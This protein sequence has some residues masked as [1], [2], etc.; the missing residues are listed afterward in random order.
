[1]NTT[2]F[3]YALE[4]ERTRSITQAAE[5]LLI[6]QPTSARRCGR[7]RTRSGT[8][9]STARRAARS[10]TEKGVRFL[11]IAREITQ[12]LKK[13]EEIG[14]LG[15][16]RTQRLSVSMPRG[17]Y[18][19]QGADPL[20]GTLDRSKGIE[21]NISETGSMGHGGQRAGRGLRAG[22]RALPDDL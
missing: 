10:P 16:E 3:K 12:Q 11:E 17:S 18:N 5:N 21:L 20:A 7:R 8:R 2:L 1:M 19:R 14:S 22:H 9:S 15:D 6:A 4:V 13:M